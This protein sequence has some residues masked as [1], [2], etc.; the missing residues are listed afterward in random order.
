M[1]LASI[2]LVTVVTPVYNGARYLAK[3]IESV[4]GQS[5]QNWKYIL[6]DNCSTDNSL[7]IAKSY[8]QDESRIQV[9]SNKEHLGAV[10]NW[11]YSISLISPD[12]HFCKI[13]HADDWL[14]PECL[15]SMVEAGQANPS[16]TI[17]SS[18]VLLEKSFSDPPSEERRVLNTDIPYSSRLLTGRE[19]GRGYFMRERQLTFAPSSVLIRCDAIPRPAAL[20]DDSTGIYM[21]IDIQCALELLEKGDFA[22]V[23]QVLV[24]AREHVESLTSRINQHARQYPEILRLLRRFGHNYLT[25]TEYDSCWKHAIA[26]YSSFLGRSLLKFRKKGF[27]RFH[28]EQLQQFGSPIAF[29]ALPTQAVREVLRIVTGPLKPLSQR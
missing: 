10:A 6:V 22:F 19:I 12:S 3:C 8:A 5:Y 1:S 17:V 13:L 21:G 18:Y 2:P 16:A 24:G 9:L 4:L 25:D 11:N 15:K 29:I 23:A 28:R 14:F 20:Y 26:D 27:W 7:E